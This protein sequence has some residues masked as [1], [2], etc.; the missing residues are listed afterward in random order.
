[1]APRMSSRSFVLLVACLLPLPGC[2]SLARLFC[3]P[4][5]SEWVSVRYDAPERT[6]ATF[7]EAI[8]RDDGAE[9]TQC[10]TQDCLERLG[11]DSFT[12]Q[13]A[14]QRL[15]DQNPGLH[16][17]GYAEVPAPSRRTMTEAVFDI[18]VQDVRIHLELARESFLEITH[19]RDNGTLAEDRRPL[20][21]WNAKPRVERI[22]DTDP[23]QS[24]FV[25]DPLVFKHAFEEDVPLDAIER[26]GLVRVWKI[27]GLS[28]QPT[29]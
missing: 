21:K 24:R 12:A 20:G 26:A 9:V 3:G 17:V 22:K 11:L 6:V 28:M 5:R 23:E 7:L 25:L 4:D 27:A 16:L 1:M 2:C 14:W 13:I 18:E 15:R 29:P 10:L 8:R 19:L